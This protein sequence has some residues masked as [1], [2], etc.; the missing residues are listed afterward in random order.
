MSELNPLRSLTLPS[1]EGPLLRANY[2]KLLGIFSGFEI[3]LF[4][5][6]HMPF[7]FPFLI[8]VKVSVSCRMPRCLSQLAGGSN[9]TREGDRG[10]TEPQRAAPPPPL[11][12]FTSF[13]FRLSLIFLVSSF[14]SLSHPPPAKSPGSR[15]GHLDNF[16][17]RVEGVKG[18]TTFTH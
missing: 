13:S 17:C 7:F 10:R 3:E 8:H 15:G 18:M 16:S 4:R 1:S 12:L 9:P 11:S 6:T 5:R 14:F 2:L